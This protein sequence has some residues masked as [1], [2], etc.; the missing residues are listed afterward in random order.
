MTHDPLLAAHPVDIYTALDTLFGD[1]DWLAWEPET[2]L[3]ELKQEVSEEAKDKLLAVLAMAAHAEEA[4]TH[5][6]AFEKTVQAFCNNVCV[7][8]VYQP[9]YVEEMCYAVQQMQAINSKVHPDKPW[10][11]SGEVPGYVA[12]VAK[13]RGWFMLPEALAFAQEALDNL[14][15]TGKR[16]EYKELYDS[17]HQLFHELKK[18]DAEALL[19]DK[20]LSELSRD[21]DTAAVLLRQLTGALLYDPTLPY[22]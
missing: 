2:I 13:Y 22:A 7:M 12:A 16:Q 10:K 5:G 20:N 21:D 15:G 1:A 11:F 17:V 9:P 6:V 19:H 18:P 4:S 14:A 8:D 3:L